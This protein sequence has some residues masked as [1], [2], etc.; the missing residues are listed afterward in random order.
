MIPD[1]GQHLCKL[2]FS[3]SIASRSGTQTQWPSWRCWN[4][5]SI[6][7]GL[8]QRQVQSTF[9]HHSAAVSTRLSLSSWYFFAEH[10]RCS[11]TLTRLLA[12]E[13]DADL[14]RVHERMAADVQCKVKDKIMRMG[15]RKPLVGGGLGGCGKDV[16]RF[17]KSF[18]V[19]KT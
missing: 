17:P 4:M 3:F 11:Q 12:N 9:L 10:R 2:V 14:K 18:T 15:N 5:S 7:Q 19:C 6:P 1:V 8:R 13:R 16:P